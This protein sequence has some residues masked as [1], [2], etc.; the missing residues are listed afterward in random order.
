[1]RVV[2]PRR[3]SGRE[4]LAL[5]ILSLRVEQRFLQSRV[6]GFQLGDRPV[7]LAP[8]GARVGFAITIGSCLDGGAGR[9]NLIVARSVA[10]DSDSLALE[11]VGEL[12]DRPYIFRGCCMREVGGLGDR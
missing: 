11:R 5:Q 10:V 2:I 4:R 1:M 3:V 7:Q 8:L 12:V 6:V 9:Q